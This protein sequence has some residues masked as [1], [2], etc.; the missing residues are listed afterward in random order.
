MPRPRLLVVDDNLEL[1]SLL[2]HLFEDAGYD[3]VSASKAKQAL[4]VARGNAPALAVLDV[5][6]PDLMANTADRCGG[7]SSRSSSP[8]SSRRQR[9]AEAKQKHGAVAWF[10]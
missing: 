3:V 2:T 8:A 5:L 6:L 1:L 7:P 9:W 4:D 10:E